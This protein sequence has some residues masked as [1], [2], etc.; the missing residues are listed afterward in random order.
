MLPAP[1]A[2]ELHRAVRW[3][4][5][6]VA[7]TLGSSILAITAGVTSG[8]LLLVVFGSVGAVDLLGSVVLISQ[9]RHVLR[10]QA[11][12]EERERRALLVIAL[13]MTTIA[14]VTIVVSALHLW[15]HATVG[16][17]T[18]GSFVAA[19]S[20]VALPV[21]AAGKHRVGRRI[22]SRALVADAQLSAIGGALATFTLTGTLAATTLGWWWLDPVGSLLIAIV[23]T[24]T[25]IGHLRSG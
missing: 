24:A 1:D 17:S 7:W 2:H 23:G 19:G 8:S 3:S 5:A 18:V 16:S 14:T 15:Q 4:G 25:A 22:A 6:S 12:S 9:F 13:A 10:H 11:T 21:L 20:V